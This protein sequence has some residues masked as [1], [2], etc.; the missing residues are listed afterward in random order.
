MKILNYGSLNI[1]YVYNVDTLVEAG[2]T[3]S[4]KGFTTMAGGK[5]LNQSIAISKAG[6]SEIYHAGN[7]GRN[8]EFLKLTLLEHNVKIDYIKKS[9]V[10]TGHAIIQ[11]SDDA[12]HTIIVHG[13]SNY[14]NEKDIINQVINEFDENDILL[15]QNEINDVAYIIE[16]AFEKK[17]RIFLNPAPFDEKVFAYDLHKIDTLILN[18]QELYLL[19]KCKNFD[20]SIKLLKKYDVNIV[21]TLGEKGG[22]YFARDMKEYSY[23]CYDVDVV[24]T[25]A[26]GDAFVGYFIAGIGSQKS[27]KY[28]LDRSSKAGALTATKI[29]SA[30]SIPSSE[31]VDKFLGEVSNNEN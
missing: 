24:D 14:N 31:D 18:E 4:D 1:D 10:D 27:I 12:E 23:P 21:I 2:T 30:I 15:I 6:L 26:V 3:K 22:K 8:G 25:T 13:G 7:I 9:N 20:E 11:I 28:I 17:M 19:V 16:K 5:G 29:G